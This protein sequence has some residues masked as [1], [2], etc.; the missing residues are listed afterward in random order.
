MATRNLGTERELQRALEQ[1]HNMSLITYA[2]TGEGAKVISIG[3]IV[4]AVV[5]F[6]V[7]LEN[8]L[9]RGIGVMCSCSSVSQ[10]RCPCCPSLNSHSKPTSQFGAAGEQATP[11]LKWEGSWIIPAPFSENL[12]MF[13][14]LVLIPYLSRDFDMLSTRQHFLGKNVYK[15]LEKQSEYHGMLQKRKARTVK[16]PSTN[17]KKSVKT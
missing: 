3:A 2:V 10:H 12:N 17:R 11:L 6:S 4:R 1:K 8:F 15:I 16:I 13:S 7:L 14:I 5:D 9:A